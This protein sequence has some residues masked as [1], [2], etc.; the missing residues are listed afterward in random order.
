MFNYRCNYIETN[1]LSFLKAEVLSNDPNECTA[2]IIN[3]F[4]KPYH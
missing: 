2:S 1:D 3:E 4:I